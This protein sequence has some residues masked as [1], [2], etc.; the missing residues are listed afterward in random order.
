MGADQSLDGPRKNK[1]RPRS[2]VID[3]RASICFSRRSWKNAMQ[4]VQNLVNRA[5][6]SGSP[7]CR[8]P[9]ISFARLC[10][11]S[12]TLVSTM[13]SLCLLPMAAKGDE[14][15]ISLDHSFALSDAD[16]RT[17]TSAD[18]PGEWLLIYFG[19][20]HCSD[21]CPMALSAMAEA[22]D[23]I[24]PCQP[25]PTVVYHGRSRTRSRPYAARFHGCIR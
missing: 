9:S 25:Y 18:F 16:G 8:R 5:L 17:V 21:Q 1:G 11:M 22:L 2:A 3:P 20:T 24:G 4:T 23:Q 7:S 13:F 12:A 14:P 6:E 10:R 15:K 19:Y